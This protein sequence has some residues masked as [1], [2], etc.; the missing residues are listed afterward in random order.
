MERQPA[1]KILCGGEPWPTELARQLL[2]K[3]D[4]LW[5]MY[6]PTETTIWSAARRIHPEED[7]L[8]GAPTANTQFYVLDHNCPVISRRVFVG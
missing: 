8:I 6:G 2:E 5:N 1:L 7:V 4:S 3:C